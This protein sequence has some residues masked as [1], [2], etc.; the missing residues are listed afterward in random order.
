MSNSKANSSS[1]KIKNK[2]NKKIKK[3]PDT[4]QQTANHEEDERGKG[5]EN[6][7]QT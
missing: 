1:T 7:K 5:G 6:K 4:Q 3:I 2:K